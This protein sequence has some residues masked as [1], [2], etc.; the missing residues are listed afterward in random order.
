MSSQQHS[1]E[2]KAL[3]EQMVALVQDVQM[4]HTQLNIVTKD[5][6]DLTHRSA[7]CFAFHQQSD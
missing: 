4:S 2:I 3:K 1:H 6:N 5:K 7:Q